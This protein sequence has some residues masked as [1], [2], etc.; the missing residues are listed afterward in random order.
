MAICKFHPT[1]EI[2]RG[3]ILSSSHFRYT[4]APVTRLI[5]RGE[6]KAKIVLDTANKKRI[7]C[8][9]LCEAGHAY[10]CHTSFGA[11]GETTPTAPREDLNSLLISCRPASAGHRASGPARRPGHSGPRLRR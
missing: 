7:S 5:V 3:A 10:F 4:F 6:L 2:L 9:L 8:A 1:I 11:H